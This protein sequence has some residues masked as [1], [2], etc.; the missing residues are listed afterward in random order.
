MA[1]WSAKTLGLAGCAMA[2]MACGGDDLA[3][4]ALPVNG[5][6][7]SGPPGAGIDAPGSNPGAEPGEGIWHGETVSDDGETRDVIGLI[8]GWGWMTLVTSRGHYLGAIVRRDVSAELAEVEVDG[9]SIAAAGLT[10]PDGTTVADFRFSGS[11][12]PST[13]I[14]GDYSGPLDTGT[15][16]L[17]FDPASD[18]GQDLENTDGMWVVRDVT[19]NIAATFQIASGLTTGAAPSASIDGSDQDGCV[20]SGTVTADTWVSVYLYDVSLTVSNCAARSGLDISGE[21]GGPAGLMDTQRGSGANDLFVLA[22]SNDEYA[23]TFR[24]EEI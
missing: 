18:R 14:N 16:G 20:Y 21:Y 15:I 19:G 23:L 22:I 11:I 10:W 6:S 2:M 12:S 4:L 13:E 7:S 3:G 9:K 1:R 24:L 5:G 17:S 8:D